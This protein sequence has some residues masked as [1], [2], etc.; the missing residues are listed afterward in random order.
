MERLQKV[1]AQA[2][3]ASRR[4]CEQL[5]LEGRVT[6][7]GH[8]VTELGTKADPHMD[9][10]AVDGRPIQRERHVYL[11]LFK[12]RG[13]VT[14]VS[15]PQ[16]RKTVLDL[17]EGVKERIF[18]VGRLDIDTSGL[19]LLTN[20]GMLTN[21]LLHPS[22]KIYKTYRAQV[23]GFV[24]DEAILKLSRGVLLEDGM[25]AP[26]RVKRLKESGGQTLLEITI[27]EGRNRQVRRM[28]EA[29]GHPVR[30]LRRVKFAFLT[31]GHLKPG[32]YRHLT[33][34]EV[35]KLM[36]ATGVSGVPDEGP[37]VKEKA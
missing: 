28:C 29:V 22:R 25:T 24:S 6:V 26:A 9:R 34:E 14:T 16:G 36:Q 1:L 23:E 27:H 7:N 8:V 2:G 11:L 32:E 15:D 13:V 30:T 3:V 19:L 17:I 31:L 4:K 10:I 18:P 5:I 21:A 20:D 33:K 12:P 35:R 37:S